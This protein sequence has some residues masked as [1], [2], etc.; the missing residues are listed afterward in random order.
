MVRG[1]TPRGPMFDN[2][3]VKENLVNLLLSEVSVSDRCPDLKVDEAG[4][5]CGHELPQGKTPC[6]TRRNVC[7]TYSLQLWCLRK[8]D[9]NKCIYH[10]GEP[11]K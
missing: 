2:M 5:Y 1:S 11:F 4:P 10:Q 6:E 9:F 7:D 3:K 8:D